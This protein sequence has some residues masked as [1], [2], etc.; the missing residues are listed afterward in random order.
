MNGPD[1]YPDAHRETMRSALRAAFGSG[2]VDA[3][4]P[5]TGGASG[6]SVFR[7]EVRGRPGGPCS[8]TRAGAGLA[9]A[10]FEGLGISDIIA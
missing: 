5:I 1:A 2:R 10:P 7:V 3:I 6:A 4:T 9:E 8:H